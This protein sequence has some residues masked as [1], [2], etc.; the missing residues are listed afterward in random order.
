MTFQAASALEAINVDISSLSLKQ[1]AERYNSVGA[2]LGKHP[3]KKFEDR[4][5]GARR[6][7]QLFVEVRMKAPYLAKEPVVEQAPVI[8]EPVV[9][10]SVA[11]PTISA[12]NA[13][14]LVKQVR[15]RRRRQA[16]F[17]YPPSGELK[18]LAEGSLRAQCRDLMVRGATVREIENLILSF[19]VARK[20][21]GKELR[22]RTEERIAERA[23][24]L[25]RLMHTYIGY[26]LREEGDGESK[27]IF[28]MTEPEW[29]AWK[30]ANKTAA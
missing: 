24:G 15:Q 3:I 7:Q 17:M 29:Q 9:A 11:A 30:Q 8:D 14:E 16:V 25:I 27:K 12:D 6:L 10:E 4:H 1:M 23:Y 18:R 13:A 2:V 28:V 22:A 19:D 26:A 21:N 20:G 5:V